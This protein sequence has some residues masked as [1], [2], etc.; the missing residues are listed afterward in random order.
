MTNALPDPAKLSYAELVALQKSINEQIS[1]KRDEEIKVL[2]DGFAKK[3]VQQGF[4][5][6]ELIDALRPY[7]P[8]SDTK[9]P[10][11]RSLGKPVPERG[12]TYRLPDGST[13]TRSESGKGRV[14]LALEDAAQAA[15]GFEALKIN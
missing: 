6:K 2:A 5:V 15:G 11:K 13:Y 14:P 8:A 4:S 1:A 9:S 10:P 3:A 7:L 12:A